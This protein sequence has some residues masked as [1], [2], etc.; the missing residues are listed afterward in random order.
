M[1]EIFQ[2]FKVGKRIFRKYKS[3]QTRF[4]LKTAINKITRSLFLLVV[5]EWLAVDLS[6]RE[7]FRILKKESSDKK[8]NNT[9]Y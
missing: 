8:K 7:R 2:K 1:L 5:F 9:N 6:L 3:R 4:I